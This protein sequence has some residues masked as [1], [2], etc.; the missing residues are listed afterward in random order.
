MVLVLLCLS[1][2][3]LYRHRQTKVAVAAEWRSVDLL[4]HIY[5]QCNVKKQ[6]H[7]SLRFF[8][9]IIAKVPALVVM[10]MLICTM[11]KGTDA[12]AENAKPDMPRS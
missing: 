9:D 12:K 2:A 5:I 6:L 10:K 8:V 11:A 4:E 7:S 3:Y 1:A